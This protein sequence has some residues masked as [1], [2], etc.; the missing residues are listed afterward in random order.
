MGA[1]E[2]FRS[3]WPWLRHF[4]ADGLRVGAVWSCVVQPP[5]PYR[6][7]FDLTVIEVVPGQAVRVTVAG[8]IVGTAQLEIH[9]RE[10]GSELHLVSD[11]AAR[12][13][14]LKAASAVARP[15]AQLGHDW[16]LDTGLRQFRQRALGEGRGR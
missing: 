5:L 2:E 1:V 7:R 16:V 3:W 13:P 15:L 11:L 6:L 12:H 9:A 10:D 14:A 4:D 8:D